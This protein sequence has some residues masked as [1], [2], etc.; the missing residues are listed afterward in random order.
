MLSATWA[1]EALTEGRAR[2][3]YRAV[4]WICLCPSNF[5]ITGEFSPSAS[6]R[7]ANECFRW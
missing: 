1:A 3:A 7:L 5:P 2:W 6:A 4:V